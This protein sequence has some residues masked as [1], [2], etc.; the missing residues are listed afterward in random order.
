MYFKSLALLNPLQKCKNNFI[1]ILKICNLRA[2]GRNSLCQ[3]SLHFS[4]SNYAF[5]PKKHSVAEIMP[6]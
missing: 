1:I 4:L 5:R 6:G 2:E 3:V